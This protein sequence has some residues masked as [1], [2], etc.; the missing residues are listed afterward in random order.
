MPPFFRRNMSK[1]EKIDV[2][3]S[4]TPAVEAVHVSKSVKEAAKQKLQEL[5][6]EETKLVKGI[7]QNFENPGAMQKIIVRK[8]PGIPP[9][10]K[11]MWDGETYEIP[12]YVARHLNGIDV[13]AGALGDPSR[14]NQNIGTCSYPKHGWMLAGKNSDPSVSPIGEG[15]IPVQ[16]AGITKRV[17]RYGFQSMEFA[18]AVA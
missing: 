9:F 1:K 6:K 18:G 2:A 13:S 17:K 11:E 16:I 5:I 10:E 15:G 3:S 12:L 8:Y 7:F 4:V 14:R